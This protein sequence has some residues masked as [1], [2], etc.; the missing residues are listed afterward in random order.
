MRFKY[1]TIFTRVV[2]RVIKMEKTL[3]SY[4]DLLSYLSSEDKEVFLRDLLSAV[5]RAKDEGN[6]NA[7]DVCIEGWEDTVELLSIPGLR[8]DVWNQFD[9]LKNSGLI[10]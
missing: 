3:N 1:N 10:N 7:V 8:R 6:L 5:I 2:Y 4:S 9:E